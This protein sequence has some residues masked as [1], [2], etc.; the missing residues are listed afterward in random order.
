MLCQYDKK[1]KVK[2]SFIDKHTLLFFELDSITY[3]YLRYNFVYCFWNTNL[4]NT[5]SF[6]LFHVTTH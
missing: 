3:L 6:T 5:G 2:E 4:W 1:I